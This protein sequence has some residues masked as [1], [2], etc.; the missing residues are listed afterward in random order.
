MAREEKISLSN[1]A[2]REWL[3]FSIYNLN[4]RAIPSFVDGLK[5]S[6]RF[7][8]YSAIKNAKDSFKKVVEIAGVVA[9]YGYHH[10]EG[11]A[12]D[13]CTYM[14]APWRNNNPLLSADGNFGTRIIKEAS[15]ARYIYAKLSHHFH[16]I[17]NDINLCPAHEDEDIKI[18][19]YYLPIIPYV[20]LNGVSGV[21]TG[22]AC[23][24]LPYDAK[25]V[26]RACMDYLSGKSIDNKQLTPKFP[27]FTGNVEH[28]V[29][30]TWNLI[31]TYELRGNKL[32]ITEIP[33]QYDR[34]E[35]IQVLDSLEEK[36]IV[37]RY[38]EDCVNGFKFNITLN[39]S[40]TGNI[41]DTFKLRRSITENLN[42]ITQEGRLK[43]YNSPI[44]LI[45]DFVDFRLGW[46]EKRIN[47]EKEDLYSIMNLIKS[48]IK[49][50]ELVIKN[51]IIFKEKSKK[52]LTDELSV[53]KFPVDHIDAVLSMSFYHLTVEE[54][55]KLSNKYLEL[56]ERLEYLKKTTPEIEY[57]IDLDTLN[58]KLK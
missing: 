22:F 4:E 38:D 54:I 56:N 53:L 6:Q 36:G 39:K 8:L 55:D 1:L 10:G 31:G 12:A 19:K 11:A 5:P 25:E 41:I 44:Q 50:I 34:E 32:T 28:V 7:I 52:Q 27:Q 43:E 9:S 21:A 30:K 24:I 42:V 46:V 48:K 17:F 51:K 58:K 45:K 13:A 33:Y 2:N 14:S 3:D 26:T 49:F 29:D 40:F 37:V 47:K 23:N 18:P 20:L 15:A 35:Y 57:G 16:N